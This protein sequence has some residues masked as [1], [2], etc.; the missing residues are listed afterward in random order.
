VKLYQVSVF[1]YGNPLKIV[2]F[3]AYMHYTRS[4][5]FEDRP[6]Y[7]YLKKMFK[8]LMTKQNL[9]YDYMYDW[10]NMDE[11][12]KM[13]SRIGAIPDQKSIFLIL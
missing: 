8:E 9:D 13:V 4:L 10:I 2:E 3:A 6:D 5:R 11:P 7:G 1:S 12:R